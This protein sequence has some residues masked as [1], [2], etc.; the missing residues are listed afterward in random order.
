MNDILFNNKNRIKD[1]I[2]SLSCDNKS[3]YD[4]IDFLENETNYFTLPFSLKGKFNLDGGL[5]DYALGVYETLSK[6]VELKGYNYSQDDIIITSLF[7]CL[8]KVGMYIIT[9]KNVKEYNPTGSKFDELGHYDWVTKL[10]FA[11]NDNNTSL[12]YGDSGVKSYM[13]VSRYLSMSDEVI[14]SIIYYNAWDNSEKL[15]DNLYNTFN[16]YPLISLLHCA[17]V[18]TLGA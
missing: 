15:T 18:L 6:L 11:Y 17:S 14:L 13:L 9:T 3:K 10:M 8:Y 7:H 4:L 5:I 16:N 12:P 1:L 2:M